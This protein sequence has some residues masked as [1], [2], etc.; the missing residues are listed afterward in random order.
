MKMIIKLN[1]IVDAER[2]CH[3]L[4]RFLCS[5]ALAFAFAFG[6]SCLMVVFSSFHAIGRIS[7]SDSATPLGMSS[8]LSS[9]SNEILYFFCVFTFITE[10]YF[11]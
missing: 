6:W 10:L 11:Y 1:W 2:V 9:T 5:S 8:Q 3:H 4:L 7:D